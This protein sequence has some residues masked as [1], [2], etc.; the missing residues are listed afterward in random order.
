MTYKRNQDTEGL[1]RNLIEKFGAA[2]Y[3]AARTLA[4]FIAELARTMK[5]RRID[6]NMNQK[7][8]A[9][10]LHTTQQHLSKY[11]VGENSPTVERLCDFCQALNLE[12]IVRDKLINQEFVHT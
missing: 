8:L 7:Y 12:L 6:M 9:V 5:Q 4:R 2:E 1:E 11:E 10:K 3:T